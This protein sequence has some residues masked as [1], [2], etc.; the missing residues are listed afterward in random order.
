MSE[1]PRSLLRTLRALR[2]RPGFA[3]IA[4]VTLALGIGASTTVYSFASEVFLATPPISAPEGVLAVYTERRSNASK[5]RLAYENWIDFSNRNRS[6]ARTAAYDWAPVNVST[7]GEPEVLMAQL[8]TGGYFEVLGISA[9]LGR[10]L[11]SS[12]HGRLGAHPVAVIS[13]DLW[14]GRLASDPGVLGRQ[15][16]INSHVFTIVGVAPEGFRGLSI[17]NVPDLWL[18]LEMHPVVHPGL[19]YS[20]YEGNRQALMLWGFGR[21]KDGVSLAQARLDA[22]GLGDQLTAEYPSANASS[23]IAVEPIRDAWVPPYLR[24]NLGRGTLLLG[25]MV[26][27][28]LLM[29]CVNLAHLMLTRAAER[30]GEI[31]IRLALGIERRVLFHRLI[32]ESWVLA[33]LGGVAGLGVAWATRSWILARLAAEALPIRAPELALDP[34]VFAFAFGISLLA[35]TVFGCVPALYAWRFDLAGSL[36]AGSG[37]SGSRTRGGTRARKVLAV[38]QIAFS[39][40]LLFVA[41]LFL[42]SLDRARNLDPGFETE[43][44]LTVAMNLD[45]AGHGETSGR[46][47]HQRILDR[48]SGLPG[49]ETAALAQAGPLAWGWTRSIHMPGEDPSDRSRFIESNV[50]GP[51]FFEALGIQIERGRAFRESDAARPEVAVVNRA[52]ADTVWPGL[53]PIGRPFRIRSSRT[54]YRVEVIGVAAEVDYHRIG[55]ESEPYV[56]LPSHLEYRADMALVVRTVTEPVPLKQPIRRVLLSTEPDLAILS[57]ATVR[58]VLA[59]ALWPARATSGV[60]SA[61]GSFALLLA[62]A[63]LFGVMA[64]ATVSRRQEIGLRIAVGATGHDIASMLVRS[65]LALVGLGLGLGWLIAVLSAQVFRALLFVGPVDLPTFLGT[66]ALLLAV[67]MAATA[68]PALRAMAV[69]PVTALRPD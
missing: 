51:G 57:S 68:L 2:H 50:V 13:H 14:T 5:T 19:G 31:A 37:R 67:A 16:R 22:V 1:L 46:I 45:S 49:V 11:A 61:F 64:H 52:F 35:G 27:L 32:S 33:V 9:P 39:V 38:A 10:V 48:V 47:V 54:D 28:L 30:R 7:G 12:D 26:A 55:Q 23:T 34:R 58:E 21:L 59:S 25:G 24:E 4:I 56:Y 20:L 43:K 69:D 62:A 66:G 8:V 17:S 18:P 40:V 63:G 6:F 65:S 44:L 41:G 42:R 36:R 60:L 3:L 15:L 29:V 53:D